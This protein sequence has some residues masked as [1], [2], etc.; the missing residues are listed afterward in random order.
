MSFVF[1]YLLR[2]KHYQNQIN[3]IAENQE[4]IF[5][6]F[7]H[8]LIADINEGFQSSISKLVEIKEYEEAK[9]MWDVYKEEQQKDFEAKFKENSNVA[10][11][12]MQLSRSTLTLC[13]KIT[14]TDACRKAFLSDV[15]VG[16]FVEGIN[17][18]LDSMT[19]SKALKLK[20]KNPKEYNFEPKE[21]TEELVLCYA[22]M[23]NY[24]RFIEAV[25][26]D[27]RSYREENFRKVIKLM[28]KYKISIPGDKAKEFEIFAKK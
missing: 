18:T 9:E 5:E 12:G 11:W 25:V 22:Y 1:H 10:K 7:C 19:S 17:Y 27:S 24:E 3:E 20:I 14:Q 28:N 6:K 8:F 4:F 26:S 2:D 23:S 13:V 16:S 21:I 15:N